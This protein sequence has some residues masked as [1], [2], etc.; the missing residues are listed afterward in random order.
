[1]RLQLA[2]LEIDAAGARRRDVGHVTDVCLFK[3]SH[4]LGLA[5]AHASDLSAAA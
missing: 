1:M 5:S 4:M 2:K 3:L